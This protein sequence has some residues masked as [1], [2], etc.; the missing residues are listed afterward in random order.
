[1]KTLPMLAFTLVVCTVCS[2]SLLDAQPLSNPYAFWFSDTTQIDPSLARN[3]NITKAG[4]NGRMLLKDGHL[5]FADGTRFRIVGTT[6]QWFSAFPDS[7]SAVQLAG[8][9]RSM[10]INCVR[11]NTFDVNVWPTVSMFDAAESATLQA[12]LSQTQMKKFDWLTHQLREHG[13][14]YALSF[15]S[16]W[17]PKAADGV[18][19]PDSISWGARVPSMFNP[20]VQ[21]IQRNIIR[22]LMQHVNQFTGL[23]YKDDPAVAFIVAAE[24]ASLT[25]YWLYTQDVVRP[26]SYGEAY[27]GSKHVQLIDSL[28]QTWLQKSYGTD[29]ALSQAWSTKAANPNNVLINGDFEDPFSS[30][31]Q[32]FV[33][34]T[35]GAQALLQYS[36]AEKHEGTSCA[37]IR[38]NKL[39]DSRSVYGL[40][41][42]QK[43]P[44][45]RRLQTYQF[46]FWA[47]TIPQRAKRSMALY[48][49]NGTS[50]YNSYGLQ[51]EVQL[52]STWQ[53][54]DFTFMSTATDS[55]TAY[56]GF[57]MGADSGDVYLD[58]VQ[59][60]ET[61]VTG[62]KSGESISKRNIPLSP[63]RETT[64]TAERA[65]ANAA[66][67]HENLASMFRNIRKL[68][69]DT[70][71]SDVLM[72]PSYRFVSHYD[73]MAAPDYEVF[74]NAEWRSTAGSMLDE[75]Y[76]G[77]LASH[78]Q[79][80][81]NGKAFVISHLSYQFPRSFQSEMM[82]VL[83]A[84]NGLQ[85][86]DGIFFSVYSENMRAGSNR[87]DSNNYWILMNKPNVLSLFPWTSSLIRSAAVSS[88][89]KQVLIKHTRE[90]VEIP[91][92]HAV[93]N[94]S[95]SISPDSRMA[96]FR[97]VA[98]DLA[99]S[100]EESFM[101]HLDISALSGTVDLAA[102]DAENEQ[103]FWDATTG[104]MRIETPTHVAVMGRLEGQIVTAD[105][106]TAEQTTPGM[107]A[108]VA[109]HSLTERPLSQ[110][111][112][113][114]LTISTRALN[115]GAMFDADNKELTRW[116]RGDIQ[117]E[118]VGMRITITAPQ[119]D[120]LTI[121]PLSET[122]KP[123]ASQKSI[124]LTR[125]TGNKFTTVIDTKTLQTPWYKL[126]FGVTTNVREDLSTHGVAVLSQPV[127]DGL[128]RMVMPESAYVLR[129]I[130]L[131]GQDV[132]T[133]Q[134]HGSAIDVS[135]LAKGVYSAVVMLADG[136]TVSRP[137]VI[138]EK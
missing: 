65:K 85:D 124:G 63:M 15:Q 18:I 129:I 84:Y 19:Q 71:K 69:R 136:G 46:S 112:Q 67:L 98:V 61:A 21:Q 105:I 16:T 32:F 2:F 29:Q 109:M 90:S 97:R 4:S 13:I 108:L 130:D 94:Y 103:I 119:F 76:G 116:G 57:L 43:I 99:P 135:H 54:F 9:L 7:A 79:V 55:T 117:M 91:S 1:M 70:L 86:W 127:S 41:L 24:D 66:F 106:L 125:R 137:F 87:I 110:S 6:L 101:P 42:N 11:F 120:S 17:T 52:T 96:L 83:P 95:L 134:A 53:K 8:R 58:D 100:A 73:V 48:I 5:A 77:T 107:H 59:F 62:L 111:E 123:L 81:P 35:S 12:G 37:R 93:N 28:W 14:Y 114:L 92:L 68:V 72:C 39:D 82:S 113:A 50:P 118:G 131:Q 128:L 138:N 20:V 49:Y 132:L 31:W 44:N 45:M 89:A 121:I 33:N 115:E 133:A 102:L 60:R 126:E 88:S 10:G 104:R 22:A 3:V 26:N 75:L 25:A 34:S 23:A 40:N 47:K 38:I 51:T 27:T 80:R 78:S 64:I 56:V 36:D 30:V 74:A 122:G